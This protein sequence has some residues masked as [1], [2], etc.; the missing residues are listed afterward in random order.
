MQCVC[1]R[2]RNAFEYCTIAPLRRRRKEYNSCITFYSMHIHGI[3][4]YS[5]SYHRFA[6]T[7]KKQTLLQNWRPPSSSSLHRNPKEMLSEPKYHR[8]HISP[9]MS[10]PTSALEALLTLLWFLCLLVHCTC[11]S[12]QLYFSLALCLMMSTAAQH[13]K[14]LA[15]HR[16]RLPSSSIQQLYLLYPTSRSCAVIRVMNANQLLTVLRSLLTSPQ[17]HPPRNSYANK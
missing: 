14:G 8:L 7:K 5:I 2:K 3:P 17:A 11:S 12:S 15:P 16:A 6:K 4:W 9:V 10:S 1:Y 13:G